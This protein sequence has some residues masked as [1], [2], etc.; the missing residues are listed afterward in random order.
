MTKLSQHQSA[1]LKVMGIDH[2]VSRHGLDNEAGVRV[3]LSSGRGRWLL[4]QRQPWRGQF[5]AL[6]ADITAV[7]GVEECRFGQWAKSQDA[8]VA[9]HELSTKGIKSVLSFGPLPSQAVPG[10]VIELPSLQAV[11][12]EPEAKQALW[13]KLSGLL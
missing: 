9:L 5:D 2:W 12:S 7:L 3:R 4:V 13:A 8:G 10:E 6:L 1:C 11:H